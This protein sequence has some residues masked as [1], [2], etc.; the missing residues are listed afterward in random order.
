MKTTVHHFVTY[1][2]K[3]S[4]KANADT[5][6]V[7][8]YKNGNPQ[9][10]AHYEAMLWDFIAP[11]L[12]D[13]TLIM[14]IPSSNAAK[15][16]TI[17]RTCRDLSRKSPWLIDATDLICKTKS[18]DSF[19]RTGKRDAFSLA[20]SLAVSSEV[21]GHNI[22]LLD[23]VTSTGISMFVCEKLLLAAGAASVTCIAI[24]LT[25]KIYPFAFS[26]DKA[27]FYIQLKGDNAGKPLK[28]PIPNSIGIIANADIFL[29][30]YLYYLFL[31]I[32]N[33]GLYRKYIRGSV[34]PY[35][36]QSDIALAM[37]DWFARGA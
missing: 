21:A 2:P 26:N 34:V 25:Y 37:R 35:I 7:L 4:G 27:N 17:T 24:A 1:F 15:V 10:I 14:A 31:A 28:A 5:S 12:N 6:R 3:S 16:N 36:R 29:P 13:Y 22:L 30:E 8:A 9:A 20:D 11:R 32:F 18:H 23:D 19:C 33:S